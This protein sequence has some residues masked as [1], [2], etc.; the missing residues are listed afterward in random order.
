MVITRSWGLKSGAVIDRARFSFRKLHLVIHIH[1][2]FIYLART[3]FVNSILFTN[4]KPIKTSEF[5][6]KL[7]RVEVP[8]LGYPPHSPL[9]IVSPQI[10]AFDC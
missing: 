1:R 6:P 9:L 4:K 7:S 8:R 3:A 5:A 10:W 2:W